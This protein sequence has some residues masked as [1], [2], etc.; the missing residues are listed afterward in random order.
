MEVVASKTLQLTPHKLEFDYQFA[1]NKK[2]GVVKDF[3]FTPTGKCKIWC[4]AIGYNHIGEVSGDVFQKLE[5]QLKKN[6]CDCFSW[7]TDLYT[8]TGGN[9]ISKLM[10]MSNVLKY[11]QEEWDARKYIEF[12]VEDDRE[13]TH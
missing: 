10:N 8:I 9:G 13:L 6:K 7:G 1:W 5:N 12:W 11:A 4:G 2:N 3:W